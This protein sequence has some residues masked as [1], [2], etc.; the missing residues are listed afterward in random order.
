MDWS[1]KRANE[2]KWLRNGGGVEGEA[3]LLM[4][5]AKEE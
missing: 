2:N 1:W 5:E 3:I 4:G